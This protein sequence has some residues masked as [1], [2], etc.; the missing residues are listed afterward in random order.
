[1]SPIGHVESVWRHPVKSMRGQAVSEIFVGFAGVSG[2]RLF[3][4]RSAAALP[5][6]P[7][8]TGRE[9]YDVLLCQPGPLPRQGR[10]ATQFC[11]AEALGPGLNPIGADAGDLAVDVETPSGRALAISGPELLR[12]LV[13]G[14]GGRSVLNLVPSERVMTDCRPVRRFR[15]QA[16]HWF[17]GHGCRYRTQPVLPDDH[18]RS[19]YGRAECR[20]PAQSS[21]MARRYRGRLC[22]CPD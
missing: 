6:F 11:E 18:A 15:A 14:A 5:G 20:N 22:R 17:T 9:W 21:T 10:G 4:F 2:D 16:P 12:E 1:M 19:G 3:A 7:F 13:E 8:F